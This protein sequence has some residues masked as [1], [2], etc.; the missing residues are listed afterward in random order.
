M[1]LSAF[2]NKIHDF[3][4]DSEDPIPFQGGLTNIRSSHV[5][6]LEAEATALLPFSLRV[7][8]NFTVQQSKVDSHQQL[9]DPALAEQI[10]I[11]NGGPF[12]GND[13]ADR[14]AAYSMASGD[15][16]GHDLPKVP[17]FTL[18]LG[19]QHTLHLADGGQL[20][21]HI[22]MVYRDPY[23]FRIYNSP[24][25]D[26]LPD[27]LQFD[28]NFTYRPRGGHWHLDFLIENLT[29]TAS[30]N[31]RYTDNFGTFITA[32]YYVPPLQFIGRIGYAF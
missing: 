31:S 26:R 23:Y 22:H 3:Q 17:S 5:D 15:V 9:L 8:G 29:D 1:N 27:Q 12:N 20:L 18:N 32:N 16:Y 19:L 25:T 7:D 2:Y 13:V 30:V 28:M 4:V 10:D 21:S 11:A 6:G 14:F 24:A